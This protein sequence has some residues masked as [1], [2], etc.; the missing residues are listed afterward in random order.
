MDP[1]SCFAGPAAG[2]RIW[3]S[4]LLDWLA[5]GMRSWDVL[6]EHPQF[7]IDDILAALA[8]G[9]DKPREQYVEH[10]LV[11]CAGHASA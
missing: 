3:V 5:G 6:P 1:G 9:A 10:P 4:L 11:P 2:G 7:A 8:Y